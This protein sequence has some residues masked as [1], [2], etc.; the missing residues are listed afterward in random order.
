MIAQPARSLGSTDLEIA[1]VPSA[2][3]GARVGDWTDTRFEPIALLGNGGMADV[4]LAL[5]R[6]PVGF[7]KLLALKLLRQGACDDPEIVGMFW[8]EAR[9]AARLDHENLV[10]TFETGEIERRPFIAMEYLQGQ[11]LSRVRR[12]VPNLPLD[13]KLWVISRALAGLHHA[14]ELRARDEPLRIVHRDVSPSN[15]MLTY[16]GRVK[17]LDFGI[18]KAASAENVTRLGVFKGKMG[19][20][21]PEQLLAGRLDRRS[22]I[23]SAG[24]TLWE[25]LVGRRL[26]PTNDRAALG[27]RVEGREDL[28]SGATHVPEQLLKL[29]ERAMAYAPENRFST[30]EEM[31]SAIE[32]HLPLSTFRDAP[33][34]L[35][36]LLSTAFL[37]DRATL[38]VRIER[39]LGAAE[40]ARVALNRST[41]PQPALE[42]GATR[43]M[44]ATIPDFS[45]GRRRAAA[46]LEWLRRHGH[47]R[48]RLLS[49]VGLLAAIALVGVLPGATLWTARAQP[50]PLRDRPLLRTRVLAA[51][52]AVPPE[53]AASSASPAGS[54]TKEVR[55]TF[56]ASGELEFRP[57]QP[58]PQTRKRGHVVVSRGRAPP[59]PAAASTSRELDTRDPW[60]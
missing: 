9:L 60:K 41:V 26:L 27:R 7:N 51:L 48:W 29:C 53:P 36:S 43:R 12:R 32:A 54:E 10:D 18:A 46:G 8:D 1:L 37:D 22:D 11:P 28:R 55:L 49:A 15:L 20:C 3:A 4:Y 2:R 38:Q 31:A 42:L 59:R 17:L 6:G 35:G 44:L 19:Y 47:R 14:H 34:M 52:S 16:D 50:A 23:F 13:L 24:V 25:L 5:S 39:R 40:S 57:Q 58:Q 33:R 56:D 45:L 21:S 30:A